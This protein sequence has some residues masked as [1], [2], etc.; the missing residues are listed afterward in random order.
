[1]KRNVFDSLTFLFPSRLIKKKHF[2]KKDVKEIKQNLVI[3]FSSIYLVAAIVLMVLVLSLVLYQHIDSGYHYI[4]TMGVTSLIGSI[5]M[6]TG[7]FI[8]GV[9]TIFSKLTSNR[10]KQFVLA[11]I[12]GDILFA[13]SSAYMLL[14][15]FADAQMGYLSQ[16][17]ALSPGVAF[18]AIL[19]LIQQFCWIDALILDTATVIGLITV[20]V[21]GAYAYDM[22]AIYYYGI[23]AL[24]YPLASYMIISLLFFVESQRY[25][26]EIENER[27]HNHAYYDSLTQCKNR[28]AL[29]EFLKENVNRWESKENINLLI[30]LF[31]IDD[32]RLYNNQF[33]HLGGDYCLKSIC[34]AVRRE[35]R[36]PNLD[37]FRYGGEE[38]L[39]FFELNNADEAPVV[40]ERVRHGIEGLDITAPKGAP[41]DVVT[42]SVGGLLMSNIKT[43]S[44]EE[45][46][47]IVDDYLYKAKASGK[48]VVCYN[49][50]IIK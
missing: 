38:F 34:D 37:F 4:A 30:V 35:F 20:S 16:A 11:R 17:E 14:C 5:I 40:L 24:I 18:V 29:T 21:I 23:T 10:K 19:L 9:I 49:G 12:G 50:E 39:L 46:M 15:I 32:F 7:C 27:L 44:F 25:E 43:F 8:S 47:K 3:S 48:D 13:C 1:M 42:I 36:S 28:H 45:E 33:S 2:T 31:D 26:E 41:K 22:R 6:V